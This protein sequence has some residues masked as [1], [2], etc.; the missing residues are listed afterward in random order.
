MERMS[1][2]DRDAFLELLE[3]LLSDKDEEV[4]A[5]ARAIKQQMTDADVGWDLL[6]VQAPGDDDHDED[7]DHVYGDDHDGDDYGDDEDEEDATETGHARAAGSPKDDL[8]LIDELLNKH[9]VSDATREELEEY[10]IDIGDGDFTEA[11][12]NYLLALY[13]RVTGKKR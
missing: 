8:A 11:D 2:I 5:S 13:Q 10:K 3:Q 9:E 6:L 1:E 12:H 7:D 4:L